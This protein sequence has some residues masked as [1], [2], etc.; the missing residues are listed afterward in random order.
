MKKIIVILI[1]VLTLSGCGSDPLPSEDKDYDLMVLFVGNSYTSKNDLPKMFEELAA[2]GGKVVY[3][4]SSTKNNSALFMHANLKKGIGKKTIGKI[5]SDSINWDYVIL[6][7]QSK[8]PITDSYYFSEGVGELIIQIETVNATP[9]LYMTWGRR[10]G[11]EGQSFEE[12]N[13][14]LEFA[15]ESEAEAWDALL[16]PAGS[17]WGKMMA[18]DRDFGLRLWD[19]DGSHPSYIGSYLNACVFYATFFE[20]S[21]VGLWYDP[22]QIDVNDAQYIQN[23]VQDFF[24]KDK[25]IDLKKEER[26]DG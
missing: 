5:K 2:S 3:Q 6:Q 14:D 11:F 10:D 19:S 23:F 22:A 25:N 20:E 7:E 17:A 18:K 8:M 15:Y 1:L 4:A 13:S 16:L 21:P 9:A 26:T 24:E 12:M